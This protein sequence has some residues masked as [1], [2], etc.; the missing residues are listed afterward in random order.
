MP[1]ASALSLKSSAVG[2][3]HGSRLHLART[4][5]R[6]STRLL[7]V[8]LCVGGTL[9]TVQ[10]ADPADGSGSCT[11]RSGAAIPA[12]VELYT[13]EGCSSCPP[14]DRWLS[15]LTTQRD[16]IALAFHVDYWDHLGWMDPF[17]NPAFTATQS[18]QQ[19]VNGSRFRYTPQVTING[20]EARHWSG[21]R[22]PITV[23]PIAAPV[24]AQLSRDG[25]RYTAVVQPVV[26]AKARIG[27]YWAV[28]EN[29]LLSE[30][31]RGEN[32]GST[33]A[34]DFVVRDYRLVAP[35]ASTDGS[36]TLS[37]S[38]LTAPATGRRRQI[39]LVVFDAD[40]G[41]PVQ[42]VKLGC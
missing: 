34:H 36:K 16:V 18:Q 40:T 29:G 7:F 31:R 12:V 6:H 30:V 20:I 14:A 1:S 22:A 41:R 19:A 28:T 37:F 35:W 2:T 9:A 21:L 42:A 26:G 27:A 4:A 39:N 3:D 8:T 23:A 17:G 24:E 10:A 15:T 11:A 33:L 38:P 32:G 5:T 25:D 13:S